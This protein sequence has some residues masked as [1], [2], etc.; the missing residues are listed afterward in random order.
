LTFLTLLLAVRIVSFGD[1]LTAPR[2]GVVTYSEMLAR[3]LHH[4]G[5]A[6]DV[7]NSGI[8]GNTSQ[9]ARTRFKADVLAKHP[10]L[11]IIQ[12]GA[13]DAAIDVW[14]SP[15]ASKP[16]VS[17]SEYRDNLEYLIR[18]LREQNSKVIL[19]TPNRFAWTP[20]LRDL[21][22]KPPY[23]VTSDD[24]FN[25]LLDAYCDVMREIARVENVPLVDAAKAVP[26]SA[27]LDGMHPNTE[28]HGIVAG[29]L[30]PVVRALL[31]TP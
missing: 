15:P 17:I 20:K 24:G 8:P 6:V 3:S 10:N 7:I 14:K 11:V 1:S 25:F 26:S 23:R 27:L 12:L 31:R 5:I 18:A 21:Y 16:R 29:L 2:P 4:H 13:N 22:G 28:G 30:L 19:M 9:Q